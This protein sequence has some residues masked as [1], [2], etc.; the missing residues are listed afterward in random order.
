[1]TALFVD[2]NC[3]LWRDKKK[4]IIV[5]YKQCQSQEIFQGEYFWVFVANFVSV[6]TLPFIYRRSFAEI[7][8]STFRKQPAGRDERIMYLVITKGRRGVENFCVSGINL[9]SQVMRS[10]KSL[11]VSIS[12]CHF[13]SLV[14]KSFKNSVSTQVRALCLDKLSSSGLD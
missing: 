11:L 6:G 5:L 2:T 1:M 14:L 8:K 7:Q 12:C 10:H 13:C 4:K 3:I 9:W